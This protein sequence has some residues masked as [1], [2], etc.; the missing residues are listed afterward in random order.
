[1]GATAK[2]YPYPEGTDRVMDGDDAIHAL[3]DAVDVKLGV[4]AAGSVT[5]AINAAAS[6]TAAVTFPAGRFTAPPAVTATVN[7]GSV[8]YIAGIGSLTASGFTMLAFQRD[9][10]AGTVSLTVCW[11]A[12]TLG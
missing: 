3:A 6:G 7:A 5:V 12:R 11:N 10:T 2:G 9:G 4:A 8:S 1:M